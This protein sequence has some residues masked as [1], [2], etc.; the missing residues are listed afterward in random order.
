[1]IAQQWM[2]RLYYDDLQLQHQQ[3]NVSGSPHHYGHVVPCPMTFVPLNPMKANYPERVSDY[4]PMCYYVPVMQKDAQWSK[5]T[6]DS[7]EQ[8]RANDS[9][10][11]NI[12]ESKSSC[13][14]TFPARQSNASQSK[15]S[16]LVNEVKVCQMASDILIKTVNFVKNLTVFRTL[17]FDDQMRLF[18]RSWAELFIIGLAQHEVIFQTNPCNV[19]TGM[20]A[21]NHFAL[22]SEIKKILSF[23]ERC[24]KLNITENEYAYFKGIVLFNPGKTN[25][26]L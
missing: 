22:T 5:G 26:Q 2:N 10:L 25:K 1:M 17:S 19:S 9:L 20:H 12:L 18:R 8:G 4:N 11:F 13:R 3:D 24:S 15:F 7:K 6:R 23:I 14:D 16:Q 21:G